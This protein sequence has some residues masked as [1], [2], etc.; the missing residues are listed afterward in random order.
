MSKMFEDN[1][2]PHLTAESQVIDLVTEHDE[3]IPFLYLTGVTHWTPQTTVREVCKEYS[4]HETYLLALLSTVTQGEKLVVESLPSFSLMMLNELCQ[5]AA[6]F[7]LE[8]LEEWFPLSSGTN[9]LSALRRCVEQTSTTFKNVIMPHSQL[10]YELYYSPEFTSKRPDLFQYS[11]EY[12]KEN[13]PELKAAFQ[14]GVSRLMTEVI[15]S[16]AFADFG[17]AAWLYRV[18]VA[19][20]RVEQLLLKPLVL[21][22]EESVVATWHKQRTA[23]TRNTYILLET[24]RKATADT[25]TDREKE[26]LQR[27]AAGKLNKEIADELQVALTTVITHRKHLMEKLGI[28]SVPGL[29]VYA[30]THGYLDPSL[31]INED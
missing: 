23:L 30:Y 13:Q 3:L 24:D 12:V 11:I 15:H 14:Q 29:T 5:K 19:L 20:D 21:Q 8:K 31:L 27:I 7:I 2:Y 1:Q 6:D 10:V 9:D 16:T 4:L 25:L 22:M 28:K 18:A 17:R 26:V